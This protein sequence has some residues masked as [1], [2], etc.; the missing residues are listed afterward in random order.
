MNWSKKR[1]TACLTASALALTIFAGA[2]PSPLK[3]SHPDTELSTEGMIMLEQMQAPAAD[4]GMTAYNATAVVNASAVNVRSGPSTS[5]SKIGT[6]TKNTR[7]TLVGKFSGGTWYKFVYGSGYGYISG[8]YLSNFSQTGSVDANMTAYAGTAVT[9]TTLNVRSGPGT[10]YNKIGSVN[11]G[12]KVT[13]VGKFSSSNW[14]KITYGSGY[15]YVSGDYL[16]NISSSGGSGTGNTYIATGITTDNLNVRSGRGTSYSRLGVLAKGSSVKIIDS[17]SGWYKIIYGSGFGYISASYIKDYKPVSTTTTTT[18]PTTKP[19]TTT[20]VPTTTPPITGDGTVAFSATAKTT[21]NLN[22]RSGPSTSYSRLGTLSKGSA[23]TITGRLPDKSWYKI[24]YGGKNG[25]VSGT[26]LTNIKEIQTPTT[27]TTTEPSVDPTV[28]K[29]MESFSGTGVTTG[30]LNVRKGPGTNYPNFALLSTGTTVQLV[31]YFSSNNWYKIIYSS[32]YGYVSGDY[33]KNIKSDSGLPPITGDAKIAEVI[34]DEALIFTLDDSKVYS[35]VW[36]EYSP[37]NGF[38]PVGAK[39]YIV[40]AFTKYGQNFYR[41]ASGID[42]LQKHV[43]VTNGKGFGE[44]TLTTKPVVNGGST[45]FSFGATWNVPVRVTLTPQSYSTANRSD[46][47]YNVSSFTAQYMEIKFPST[48]KVGSVPDVSGSSVVSSA[49]WVK[50]QDSSYTLRVKL[51]SSGVFYGYDTYFENGEIKVRIRETARPK[52]ANIKY[53][54]TLEGVRIWLDAGHG[55]KD[56]GTL[57]YDSSVKE[58]NVNL[59]IALKLRDE[60]QALGATVGMTRTTDTYYELYDRTLMAKKFN[61]DIFLSIHNDSAGSVTNAS[62]NSIHYYY[63]FSFDLGKSLNNEIVS[64]YKSSIY[65]ENTAES[66]ANVNRV[67]RGTIQNV[68]AV[69]RV[70]DFPSVLIE[71]GFLSNK[72]EMQK[73]LRDDVQQNL[74]QATVR[75]II[76]YL[77]DR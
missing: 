27:T 24:N 12:A 42:V 45:I 61:A 3:A 69:T 8:S 21:D 51:R 23:V 26:Y 76:K 60:L 11:S 50:N 37:K 66:N 63:P 30:S 20:I 52:A 57:G 36:K 9:T 16:K 28:D 56:S 29:D 67:N 47:S 5:Y 19:T 44:N 31:G 46:Y 17:V 75:G 73:L 49:E 74:S 48:T 38:L 33:L 18:A 59:S 54:F 7:L 35:S 62:G 32:G 10:S 53:G 15:G 64:T 25:Y 40:K 6:V 13:L 41:L 55:G 34:S 68:F 4:S 43:K 39:D 71:Y 58:K 14:Y 77:N 70:T 72:L 2:L 22:V 65:T 1:I